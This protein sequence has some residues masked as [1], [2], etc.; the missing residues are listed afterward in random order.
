[1]AIF[2]KPCSAFV[3]GSLEATQADASNWRCGGV[4]FLTFSCYRRLPLLRND[5]VKQLFVEQLICTQR[6]HCFKLFAWVVMPEHVHLLLV[7]DRSGE[8]VSRIM[9][10]LKRPVASRV[11]RR[12]RDLDAHVLVKLTD[13]S[14]RQHF[15]Q[16]GGGYDRLIV[17]QEE[18]MEKVNYIHENPVRRGLVL[19]CV[20]WLWSSARQ[21]EGREVDGPVLARELMV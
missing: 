17:T 7:P 9:A 13:S 8:S 4:R 20:D 18:L 15:W 6:K 19:R 11:L 3:G 14:G 1:M 12:W 16:A 10:G 2:G 5:A 21:Y